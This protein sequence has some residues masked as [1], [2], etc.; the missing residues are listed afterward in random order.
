M[1][2]ILNTKSKHWNNYIDKL[3]SHLRDVYFKS[4]YYKLYEDYRTSLGH[5]FVYEEKNNLAIYPFLINPI[6]GYELNKSYYDI[7]TA[8]GYGGPIVNTDDRV[9][10]NNFEKA[11]K[12][13]CNKNNIVAEFIRFHPLMNNQKVFIDNIQVLHN[14]TTTFID[15]NKPIEEIW[16]SDIISKN[17]N[18]IRKAEKAGLTSIFDS[19]LDNFKNIYKITMD[20][21]KAKD[22]YYF[23]EE[24]FNVLSKLEH[25][26]IS[27]NLGEVT[28]ASAV[29]LKNQEFFHYH[30]AGSLKEYLKYSPNNLLLWTA[31]KYAK[32][33]NFSKFHFGGGLTDNLSDNLYK[34]KKSFCKNTADFYIGKRIHNKEIYD[35][36]INT[37]EFNNGKKAEILLQYR[38]KL[39]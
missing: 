33:N 26:C 1:I 25:V 39:H 8:Y 37:W 7:E 31:I 30:L 19:S 13:F 16:N 18:V 35:Y 28:V 3:P 24:Y 5:L 17:R 23:S 32:N 10:I 27:I 12:D 29:F 34:F 4:D 21:V 6:K 22:N 36:L 2:K 9:F 20:K 15:L 14:R 11:F 38:T